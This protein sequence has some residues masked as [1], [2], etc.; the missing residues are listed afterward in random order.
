MARRLVKKGITIDTFFSSPAKRARTTAEYFTEVFG[1]K[2]HDIV[3]IPELYMATYDS[4]VDTIRSAPQDAGT[5]ALFSH[6]NGITDF[7]NRL[8]NARI[9]HMPT[10]GVFAVQA[11]IERWRDF[12]PGEAAFFFFDFPKNRV[13]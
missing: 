4:F 3:L 13:H 1:R 2:K 7:A 6:N 8:S 10:C 11:E 5:I 12:E 9:D